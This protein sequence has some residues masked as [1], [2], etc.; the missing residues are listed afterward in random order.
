MAT[1]R[2]AADSSRHRDGG[3]R[4][5]LQLW[6]PQLSASLGRPEISRDFQRAVTEWCGEATVWLSPEFTTIHRWS[7]DHD[8]ELALPSE[9]V[10]RL[11]V[12]HIDEKG[13]VA[14]P[15]ADQ[16]FPRG[17]IHGLLSAW[18]NVGELGGCRSVP[19]PQGFSIV[20]PDLSGDDVGYSRVTIAVEP[21]PTFPQTIDEAASRFRV[22][23]PPE[24]RALPATL[25][26]DGES[27]ALNPPVSKSTDDEG[28]RL[29]TYADGTVAE[30]V[31]NRWPAPL[32]PLMGV[33]SAF[34]DLA[35]QRRMTTIARHSAK[36]LDGALGAS[37]AAAAAY[38]TPAYVPRAIVW[39][40]ATWV[41]A[42]PKPILFR[43]QELGVPADTLRKAYAAHRAGTLQRQD[44]L[45]ELDRF[46]QWRNA[47][48]EPVKVHRVWGPL[49]LFWALLLDQLEARRLFQSCN[50]CG[51]LLQGRR[52]R[53]F[54][55]PEDNIGCHRAR[56]AADQ[57]R[58]RGR[59]SRGSA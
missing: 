12:Y 31:V 48:A 2:M 51:R 21:G 50:R 17:R 1:K 25:L 27:M 55:G 49:G 35:T 38:V 28:V 9:A 10:D 57:R 34:D 18:L 19:A 33:F 30:Q 46:P 23:W 13:R 42:G 14:G 20:F 3:L 52:G 22:S 56:R 26:P 5:P 11:D 53:R 45:A 44:V 43:A 7:N 37:R 4:T 59:P 58:S 15:H 40:Y 29:V 41:H 24:G 6:L 54:C 36:D 47:M 32:N 16:R 8:V 39:L